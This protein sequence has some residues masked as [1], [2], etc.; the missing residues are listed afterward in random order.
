MNNK[1]ILR[2]AQ[3]Q[4]AYDCC[5]KAEDFLKNENVVC[6]SFESA[7][8]RKYLKL[9]HICSL[10]SYGSNIVACGQKELLPEIQGFIND[11]PYIAACFETPRLYLL[12]DILAKADARVCFMGACFLPDIDRVYGV[13]LS[14]PYELRVLTAED[15]ADLYVPAWSNALC[16]DRKQLDVLGVGA[17]EKGMLVGLAGCS[18]DCDSMWQIGVDV[19][20]AYRRQGIAGA[21]TNRLAREVFD[22]GKVPFYSAAWSNVISRKNAVRSGF[23]PAWVEAAAR[24]NA[25]IA[26]R[27]GS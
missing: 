11:A 4:S 15:F 13:E 20:P 10:V 18:A 22:R 25:E 16:E 6:E 7:Y 12:N 8:A 21:L 14:C 27:P 5:C 23:I 9:P 1:E 17:Y 2:I 3:Q 24:P 19:L 26:K